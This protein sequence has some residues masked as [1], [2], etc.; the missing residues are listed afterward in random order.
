MTPILE[1]ALRHKLINTSAI[2]ALVSTRVYPLRLPQQ[3]VL[4][5]ITY[6][7]I[8]GPV[9]TLHGERSK[10]PRQRVQI[11]SWGEF[12]TCIDTDRAV[13]AA[14]DGTVQTV[15][16]TGATAALVDNCQVAEAPRDAFDPESG[17]YYRQRD[18]FIMW[19][20]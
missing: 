16:G 13:L 1:Q 2:S 4:P 6:Q 14:L 9:I 20:Q 18:F 5:A 17:L 12:D 19:H 15:W 8:G 10:L 7:M 3:V 11:T